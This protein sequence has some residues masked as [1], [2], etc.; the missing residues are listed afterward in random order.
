MPLRGE[1]FGLLSVDK[2][3][4]ELLKRFGCGK[5]HLNKFLT[6]SVSWHQDR[7]GLTTVVFHED[8][9]NQVVGYFT[10][11]NDGLPL[12]DSEIEELG[13]KDRYPVT[14]FPAVKIGRLAISEDFQRGGVGR[15]VM[16]LVHGEVLSSPSLSAAR[17]VVLDADNDPAVLAFYRSLG[18]RESLWAEKQVKHHGRLR[19]AA[20]TIKLM[21]DI[22]QEP[23]AA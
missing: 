20:V 10:L 11:A 14:S 6:E 1:G 4:P 19:T 15:Q 23:T 8:V 3:E 5:P 13:L 7:L 18:Y 12:R 22:L 9:P 17:L 16:G 2:V 21:R